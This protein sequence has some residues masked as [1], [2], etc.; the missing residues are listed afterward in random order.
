MA[1]GSSARPLAGRTVVVTRATEQAG[2]LAELLGD[3]GAEVVEVPT[4]AIADPA[5]GGAALQAAAR[6]LGRY[7]WVVLTSVNGA[8]RLAAAVAGTQD[9]RP[10]RWP[11]AGPAVAVVG[12]GT[13][14]TCRRLGLPVTLVPERFVAEGLVEAFPDGTGTMLLA[15]AEAARPVLATGLRAKGWTVDTVVAYR[16][17]PAPIAPGLAERAA[18]ADAVTFTSGTTV[19]H[20]LAGAGHRALPPVVVCIGPVTAEAAQARGVRVAAVADPHTLAGLAAA[21]VDVF[22]SPSS[23]RSR[24]VGRQGHLE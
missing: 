14:A 24:V 23:S 13:E 22:A 8:E 17:V 4:I 16:A 18:H 6:E 12:P 20:F 2:E 9:G 5:D 3:L 7:D 10:E 19:E 15:Q 1:E 21:V 11:P